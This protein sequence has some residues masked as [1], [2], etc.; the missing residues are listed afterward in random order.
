MLAGQGDKLS[1]LLT[2]SVLYLEGASGELETLAFGSRT[3]GKVSCQESA[4]EVWETSINMEI[5][6]I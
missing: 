2:L 3:T 6:E 4:R 1:C 5:K